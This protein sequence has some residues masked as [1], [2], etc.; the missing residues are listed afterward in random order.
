MQWALND[1]TT[2]HSVTGYRETEEL[3]LVESSGSAPIEIRAPDGTVVARLPVFVADRLQNFSQFSQEFR[4][5]GSTDA[6]EYVAGIY[7]LNS[8]YDIDGSGAAAAPIAEPYDTDYVLPE[9][10]EPYDADRVAAIPAQVVALGQRGQTFFA[11]QKLDTFA[12]FG[13]ATWS[14]ADNLRL[15]A[16]G[17]MTWE[18]KKFFADYRNNWT[19]APPGMPDIT[20]G[21]PIC[22]ACFLFSDDESWNEFT[23]R[24]A[25][26]YD[27]AEDA[28]GYVSW[29]RGFRSGG[30][31]GRG[32]APSRIGPYDAE[33]VDNI[34]I[35]L[36]FDG[37]GNRLRLNPTAFYMVYDDKQEQIIEAAGA[38]T[39][40]T[41][42]N[43]ASAEFFG[44]ELELL[45][46]PTEELQLNLAIG[47][48]DAEYDE[49]MARRGPAD[50]LVD[51]SNTARL[52]RAP[53]WNISAGVRYELTLPSGALIWNAHW[54]WEDDFYTSPDFFGTERTS[55]NR[56]L[57]ENTHQ[58]DLSVTYQWAAESASRLK[59]ASLTAFVKDA[60][61]SDKGRLQSTLDVGV[62]F[63]GIVAPARTFG[64]E[65]TVDF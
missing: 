41:T 39:D 40:T 14:V 9:G 33:T 3:L 63:F 1:D 21:S 16:G 20:Q 29:S 11:E 51:V 32:T 37:F 5:N 62:F 55:F 24:F 53:E 43:A 50:P 38:A 26:E 31:N 27:F 25:T 48:V 45:A 36:R 12:L 19:P 13:E 49:F 34:E 35:G 10:V 52:L 46:T 56:G 17:R 22:E 15:T 18:S 4:L 47:Y 65:F 23:W 54:D 7:Y 44:F 28:M 6:I 42:L 60:L 57:I 61:E 8:T 59:G 64:V 58:V 30:Y 2:L